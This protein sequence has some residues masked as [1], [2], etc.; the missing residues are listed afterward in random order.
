[1]LKPLTVWIATNWKVLK[2][3]RILDHLTCLL[4]NRYVGQEATVRTG[5]G[6]KVGKQPFKVVYC[7]AAY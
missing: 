1:M 4:S 6:S 3:L 5:D 7:R 2:E